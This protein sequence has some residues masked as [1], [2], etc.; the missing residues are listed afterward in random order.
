MLQNATLLILMSNLSLERVEWLQFASPILDGS[1]SVKVSKEL[2]AQL[3]IAYA[4]SIASTAGNSYEE[5]ELLIEGLSSAT[6][7]LKTAKD[8]TPASVGHLVSGIV[9]LYARDPNGYRTYFLEEAEKHFTSGKKVGCN[10]VVGAL[11]KVRIGETLLLSIS[12]V[13]SSKVMEAHENLFGAIED[14]QNVTDQYSTAFIDRIRTEAFA[15]FGVTSYLLSTVGSEHEQSLREHAINHLAG[16][17]GRTDSLP[18]GGERWAKAA[19]TLALAWSEESNSR[20]VIS[21]MGLHMD[22][23]MEA[24]EK[25]KLVLNE[26]IKYAREGAPEIWAQAHFRLA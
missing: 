18:I 26:I 14:L 4:A 16:V 15:S 24:E 9:H 7:I 6:K 10:I 1:S 25:V 13:D 3:R 2:L 23:F 8:P 22:A 20:S 12:N 21:S 17:V 5:F 11:A 19:Y